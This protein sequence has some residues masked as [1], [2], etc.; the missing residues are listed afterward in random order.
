M[1]EVLE[2]ETKACFFC[3]KPVESVQEGLEILNHFM[4]SDC[5]RQLLILPVGDQWYDLYK[6]KIRHIWFS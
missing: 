1:K 6:N 3:R 5:E 2:K 4:C